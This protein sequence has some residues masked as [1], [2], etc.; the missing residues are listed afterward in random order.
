MNKTESKL[1]EIVNKL[2]LTYNHFRWEELEINSGEYVSYLKEF[3][4]HIS[5][6]HINYDRAIVKFYKI[7][8]KNGSGQIVAEIDSKDN[9]KDVSKMIRDTYYNV[10][11]KV[12][13]I[14]FVLEKISNELI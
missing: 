4:L 13:N 9:K 12:L 1:I 14:D 10:R 3:S 2:Y 5:F 7:Y 6:Y 8:I 11:Q